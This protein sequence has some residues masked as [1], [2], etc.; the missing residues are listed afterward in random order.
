M[1]RQVTTVKLGGS[2]LEDMPVDWWD[3]L[4]AQARNRPVMLAH[5]WSKP[6]KQLRLRNGK[7]NVVLRDR[8]G[9]Q[10]RWTTPDVIS[11]I[12]QVSGEIAARVGH[13]LNRRG[14]GMTHILGSDG[15]LQAGTAE[16]W[17]WLN[18]ELV[19]LDNLVG[20]VT[21]VD[22]SRLPV[23]QAGMAYL[24]TPLARNQAGQ[25]VNTDPTGPPPRS[26]RPCRPRSWHWSPTCRTCSST[27]RRSA[28]S[29][30][31]RPRTSATT[32]PPA[33]CARSCEL[34]ARPS[35]AASTGSS[36]ATRRPRTCSRAAAGR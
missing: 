9:N 17:W 15:L 7:E 22:T 35:S 14:V 16:R 4:A 34:P 12:K 25:E 2:C 8:Y 27:V 3:D 19:E 21:G 1:N 29:R 30:P 5:G 6:L 28:G 18:K 23:L 36:S 33:A 32:V 20:P 13:E 10:S 31:R 26:P 11:D 24:V